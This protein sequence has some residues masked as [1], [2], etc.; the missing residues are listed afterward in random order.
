MRSEKR[1]ICALPLLQDVS[2]TYAILNPFVAGGKNDRGG[3]GHVTDCG[4]IRIGA[5]ITV[6]IPAVIVLSL[7]L[8]P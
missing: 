6:T 2:T 7:L 8:S 1:I 3:P 5:V 4:H